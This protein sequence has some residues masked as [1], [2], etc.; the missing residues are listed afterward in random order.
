MKRNL[1]FP[2]IVLLSAIIFLFLGFQSK[3]SKNEQPPSSGSD[4]YQK[5]KQYE[6]IWYDSAMIFY[7]QGIDN[8]N[9][10]NESVKTSADGDAYFQCVASLAEGFALKARFDQA[11][12]LLDNAFSQAINKAS[13][14]ARLD[15]EKASIFLHQKEFYNENSFLDSAQIRL[16]KT[17]DMEIVKGSKIETELLLTWG[18]YFLALG[19]KKEAKR[20]YEA[21]EELIKNV[22]IENELQVSQLLLGLGQVQDSIALN[23]KYLQ[24]AADSKTSLYS[25]KAGIQLTINKYRQSDYNGMKETAVKSLNKNNQLFSDYYYYNVYLLKILAIAYDLNADYNN[26]LFYNQ[27]GKLIADSTEYENEKNGILRGVA[28]NYKKLGLFEK[29]ISINL[30]LL[31]LFRGKNHYRYYSTLNDLG[32]QF[33][34]LNIYDEG[35][36]YHLEALKEKKIAKDIAVKNKNVIWAKTVQGYIA[37]SYFNLGQ[38]NNYQGQYEIALP[39]L[40]TA[41]QIRIDLGLKDGTDISNNYYHIGYSFLGKNNYDMAIQYYQKSIHALIP[42]YNDSEVFSLPSLDSIILDKLQLLYPL[43]G[44]GRAL[45]Y[46]HRLSNYPNDLNYASLTFQSGSD[47]IDRLRKEFDS[48][49]SKQ[50]LMDLAR[51][52]YEWAIDHALYAFDFTKD[53]KYLN[54]AFTYAEKSKY[55]LLNEAIKES[56]VKYVVLPDSLLSR[57]TELKNQINEIKNDIYELEQN[58]TTDNSRAI[59]SLQIES[60]DLE[61]ELKNLVDSYKAEFER[62]YKAEDMQL[63]SLENVQNYLVSNQN[64]TVLEYV[65]SDSSLMVFGI[66]L[67]SIFVHSQAID[68]SFSKHLDG[69]LEFVNVQDPGIYGSQEWQSDFSSFCQDAHKLY[70]YLIA[71]VYD[72]IKIDEIIIIPDKELGRLPFQILLTEEVNPKDH[73]NSNYRGLSYLFAEKTISYEYSST[74]LIEHENNQILNKGYLGFAPEY[75]DTIRIAETRKDSTALIAMLRTDS[76]TTRSAL[77]PLKFN[78]E[79]IEAVYSLFGN[80]KYT[81]SKATK[82]FF[83]KDAEKSGILHLS[84]HGILNDHNPLFSRLEFSAVGENKDD[85]RLYAYELYNMKLDAQLA[86][87]SACETG[88]GKLRKGEGIMSLSRAFKYAGCPNIVMT[89]W[90]V[91]DLSSKDIMVAFFKNLKKGKPKNIA[92]EEARRYYLFDK[93]I[94]DKNTHPFYWAPFVL[95]GDSAPVEIESKVFNWWW[96]LGLAILGFGIWFWRVRKKQG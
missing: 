58:A 52:H 39:Y 37:K 62:S 81:G 18:D 90:S 69:F 32:N 42:S 27:R 51:E 10:L 28:S 92:L 91:N 79:E 61:D 67:D 80:Q 85:Q 47:L 29:A 60:F 54:E 83:L 96:L 55:L 36:K 45:S 65:L 20:F 53:K 73:G 31:E 15:M 57:E 75:K 16:E 24:I 21:S 1:T 63:A 23:N 56:Q 70:T 64:A 9:Q 38:L 3:K 35:E 50:S 68:S 71:P 7:Q 87:L 94:S 44:K 72:Q 59:R 12:R 76:S 46:R 95:I 43:T 88:L 26:A 5:G 11:H 74:L 86:V 41:L 22:V 49:G 4:Y 19:N 13:D 14:L 66:S 8:Y 6:T 40:D 78:K 89:L 93:A 84:M 2:L 82:A 25:V 30:D 77:N 33:V 34:S 17:K 48:Q